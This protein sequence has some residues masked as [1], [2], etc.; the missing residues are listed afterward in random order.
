MELHVNG[1]PVF[2]ATG[3]KAHTGTQPLLILVHGAGMDRTVWSG[4]TRYLAYHGVDVAA[5]DLPGHGRSGGAPLESVEAMADWI[6]AVADGLGWESVRLAGHSLGG[7]A[8]LEATA[9]RPDKVEKLGLFGSALAIPVAPMLIDG[10]KAGNTKVYTKMIEFAVGMTS[11][12]GGNPTPGLW[13]SGSGLKLMGAYDP[14]VL[15][16]DLAACD[17]Y[18]GG[19]AAAAKVTCPAQVIIGAEDRM[20]PPRNGAALA[21]AIPG[22]QAVTMPKLGHMMITENPGAVTDTAGKFL[23]G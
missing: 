8:V 12:R 14:T 19:E 3:G 22:G 11:H 9:R 4:Q 15:A 6:W 13:T 23:A 7:L 5:V 2:M 18:K 1:S 21:K 20:T 16:V 17:A 10:A